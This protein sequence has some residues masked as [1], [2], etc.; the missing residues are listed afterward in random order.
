MSLSKEVYD[1]CEDAEVCARKAEAAFNDEIRGYFLELEKSWLK[2]VRRYEFED[3][4]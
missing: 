1:C 3:S 4:F 2:F